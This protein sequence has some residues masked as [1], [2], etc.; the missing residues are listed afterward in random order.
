M[1][2]RSMSMFSPRGDNRLSKK[3]EGI[4]SDQENRSDSEDE[5]EQENNVMLSPTKSVLDEPE[6]TNLADWGKSDYDQ[7]LDKLK[8]ALP[9]KE[10]HSYKSTLQGIDWSKV[11]I[12]GRST[13]EIQNTTNA[14]VAKVRKYRTLAEI[15]GDIPE[16][17]TK[18]L[19]VN[20]P[21]P[22]LSAYNMFM[23]DFK[24]QNEHIKGTDV[25]R[26]GAIEFKALS[27]KKRKRYDEAAERAKVKYKKSLEQYYIDNPELAPKPKDKTSRKG[28]S[29]SKELVKTPFNLFYQSRRETS[30]N[31]TIQQARKEW[32]ELAF[33]KKLKY[34]QQSF[35]AESSDDASRKKLLNKKEQQMLETF[36]GKPEFMGRSAFEYFKRK[37]RPTVENMTPQGR[38]RRLIDMYKELSEKAV[39]DLKREYLDAREKYVK[40]YQAYIEKLPEDKRQAEIDVLM[41]LTQKNKKKRKPDDPTVADPQD[42]ETGYPESAEDDPPT[43]ESTTIA[44]KS[45]KKSE[46]IDE[47]DTVTKKAKK[48]QIP[49]PEETIVPKK[50]KK[51]HATPPPESD[52]DDEDEEDRAPSPT[53]KS[54]LMGPPLSPVKANKKSNQD[55]NNTGTDS[56]A[57]TS[58]DKQTGKGSKK[59]RQPEPFVD[60]EP[61]RSAKNGKNVAKEHPTVVKEEHKG[62]VKEEPKSKG[63]PEKPPN[64]PEEFYRQRIYKGKVGRHKESYSNLSTA[65]KHEI[66]EQMKAAQKKYLVEFE[67]FLK[68]LPR[69]Q[70]RKYIQNANNQQKSRP[71]EA[72]SSSE[73]EESESGSGEEESDDES[74][75]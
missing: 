44:K 40:K 35:E 25:F 23:K 7:L 55:Q 49:E 27:E 10:Q 17:V 2:K 3:F 13:K 54:K 61:V 58:S 18:L 50:S 4:Q 65:K 73:E 21:K 60:P 15:L 20:K 34:I 37:M 56:D 14:L 69:D 43:A 67:S 19:T 47:S 29:S 63:P 32:E 75:E 33:K 48:K 52:E 74:D 42:E 16:L 38:E 9:K 12:A 66:A 53:K 72:A 1:R 39:L 70:I 5:D 36:H 28:K 64:D 57:S 11:S 46:P 45:K 8:A 24:E 62:T 59:K 22:P 51:K 26:Q 31:I 71:Q 6:D 30:D 41:S 68:A